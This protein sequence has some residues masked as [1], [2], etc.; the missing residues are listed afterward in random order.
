MA[1]E[2]SVISLEDKPDP[3][4]TDMKRRFW[5]SAALTLPV[6]ILAM[7]EMLPNFHAFLSPKTSLW[8]QFL[9]STPVVL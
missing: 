8:I 2:P 7:V 3:E 1:L 6:F 9:L 5:I 4:Y